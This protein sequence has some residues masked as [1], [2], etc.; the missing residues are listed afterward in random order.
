MKFGSIS[1][2][3]RRFHEHRKEMEQY[4]WQVFFA[5]WPRRIDST[6]VVWLERAARRRLNRDTIYKKIIWRLR[7]LEDG[8]VYGPVSHALM[9][10]GVSQNDIAGAAQ[11]QSIA[12]A[13][14]PNNTLSGTAIQGGPSPALGQL[15][16]NVSVSGFAHAGRTASGG[17][18]AS[19]PQSR[20]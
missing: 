20:P 1:P 15:G 6:T 7:W 14:V 10:P 3:Q 16:Q 17:L 9:Q 19:T 5:W 4:K 11:Q 13:G 18:N 12:S 2:E 8:Y